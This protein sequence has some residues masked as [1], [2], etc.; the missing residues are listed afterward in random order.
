MARE[1]GK[2]RLKKNLTPAE[3]EA[4]KG[5]KS[6]GAAQEELSSMDKYDALAR[7]RKIKGINMVD[8]YTSTSTYLMIAQKTAEPQVFI[9][10]RRTGGDYR[11]H[12]HPNLE[13]HSENVREIVG[14]SNRI[15]PKYESKWMTHSDFVT[16]C[17]LVFKD[18]SY[19]VIPTPAAL[20]QMGVDMTGTKQAG[21]KNVGRV[22]GQNGPVGDLG[23]HHG[24]EHDPDAH[25]D[26]HP[27]Q[28]GHGGVD[29]SD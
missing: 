9:A 14:Q 15:R 2:T 28:G 3:R 11:V 19:A 4:A 7:H 16:L 8:G 21:L 1:L 6:I 25:N 27:D 18:R 29:E 17:D 13:A 26:D 5:A 12:F 23:F 10:A 24:G 20:A 22:E